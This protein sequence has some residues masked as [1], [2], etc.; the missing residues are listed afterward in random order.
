[1]KRLM[2]HAFKAIWRLALPLRRPIIRRLDELIRRNAIQPPPQVHL[3]CHVRDETGLMMD[4]MVRELVR[5]QSQVNR[6]QQT[7]EDLVPA[8]TSLSV[9]GSLDGDDDEVE[10]RFAAG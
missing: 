8:T 5:L 7:I 6:L 10:G 4:H 2:R 1:M 9:V 3:A